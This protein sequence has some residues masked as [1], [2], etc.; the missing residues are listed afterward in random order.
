MLDYTSPIQLNLNQHEAASVIESV[1]D[2]LFRKVRWTI[3]PSHEKWHSLDF[4]IVKAS[5]DALATTYASLYMAFRESVS[6]ED[7]PISPDFEK[8]FIVSDEVWAVVDQIREA[9]DWDQV[10]RHLHSETLCVACRELN[11]VP[12]A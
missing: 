7:D 9:G 1:H 8:A 11:K 2:T 6:E 3:S 4:E 10:E 12:K 5:I